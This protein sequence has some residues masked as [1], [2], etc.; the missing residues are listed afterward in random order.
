VLFSFLASAVV[1]I[2]IGI[3]SGLLGIGGGTVMVPIFRLLYNMSAVMSTATSLFAIIPTSVSGAASHLS[4]KTCLPKL[5]VALG[6]GGA[7]MSPVGVQL[8]QRSPGWLVMA[9]AAVIIGFSAYKMFR[10]AAKM[11]PAKGAGKDAAV[12][13]ARAKAAGNSLAVGAGAAAGA[14]QADMAAQAAGAADVA[15]QAAV[16][17][18]VAAQA[19]GITDMAAAARVAPAHAPAQSTD[20]ASVPVAPADAQS[21]DDDADVASSSEAFRLTSAQYLKGAAIGLVAGLA[22]GYVGVGGGFIMVPLMLSLLNVPMKLASGTSLIAVAILAIPGT[23]E[24]GLLGNIDYIAGIAIACGSIP[25]AALGARL[26]KYVP[27]RMLR[28]L[29]GCFLLVGAVMLVVK[30]IGVL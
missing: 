1:G 13:V 7:I 18:D 5:G 23:I 14:A 10:K 27:E 6:I 3:L 30:E 8:A 20:A 17:A 2:G 29:F 12:Q 16:A 19:A 24:Q 11:K 25:G 4:R 9:A 26:I 15:A 21:A 22:S 28:I